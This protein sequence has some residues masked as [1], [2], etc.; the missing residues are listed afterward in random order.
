MT[1]LRV[2]RRHKRKFRAWSHLLWVRHEP[3]GSRPLFSRPP[4]P[5]LQLRNRDGLRDATAGTRTCTIRHREAVEATGRVRE[6]ESD[7]LIFN[8]DYA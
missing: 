4:L 6:L 3:Q 8:Y 5:A 7:L 2:L 1:R